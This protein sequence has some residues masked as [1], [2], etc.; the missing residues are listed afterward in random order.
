MA[1]AMRN[2]KSELLDRDSFRESVFRRDGYR[3]VICGSS[4]PPLDAHHIMER[5]LWDDGGYYVENGATL[6][7]DREGR[8]GCHRKAEQTVL[9]CEEVR[10]A[11][12]IRQVALPDHLYRDAVYDKWGN[13]VNAD[14]TRTKGELFGDESVR[15]VLASAGM[16]PVFRDRVKYPRTY[17]LPW[18]PGRTDD[19]RVLEDTS[20]FNGRRVIITEKMDGENT[21]MYADYIHAR[22]LD[23]NSHP[24]RGWVKNLH[25]QI[26]PAIS[27]GW[28]ICGENLFAQHTLHYIDLPTYF[29]IFS[30]W[31]EN[32]T[33]LSWDE[34]LLYAGVLGLATVPV[35][36]DGLWDEAYA[37]NL[38]D[39]MDL[40]KREGY[41]VR[42]ADAFPYGA[43]RRSVAKFVRAAHAGT[44]H[45][46][47]M[48]AVVKNQIR[49]V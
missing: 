43:F 24:S 48:Q 1:D 35:L 40:T 37:S 16:L 27:P 25:A 29:M 9:S 31:D 47:M 13:I 6:C 38:A 18:S 33:C 22:S 39:T 42:L 20:L 44:S 46:W 30:I 14:G 45:N 26:R 21:T 19:D 5:R 7:D 36:F 32:N 8:A 49:S 23:S 12:G 34:T 10:A 41:V 17:H 15:K 4:E 3:C 11:A 2:D 28:R